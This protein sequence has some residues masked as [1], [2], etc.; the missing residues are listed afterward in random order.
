[1]YTKFWWENLKEK[2]HLGDIEVDKRVI[3]LRGS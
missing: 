3:P 2:D 1:M